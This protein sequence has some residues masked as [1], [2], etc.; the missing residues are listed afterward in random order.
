MFSYRCYHDSCSYF[1]CF[2]PRKDGPKT[3]T[4]SLPLAQLAFSSQPPRLENPVGLNNTTPP[5]CSTSEWVKITSGITIFTVRTEEGA[6][7]LPNAMG[8]NLDLL[9]P[10]SAILISRRGHTFD[11]RSHATS[12]ASQRFIVPF[13]TFLD[14]DL[15][16]A[17]WWG[18]LGYMQ[19][20]ASLLAC[21]LACLL[22]RGRSGFVSSVVVGFGMSN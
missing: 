18:L 21:L 12:Q 13:M 6:I 15:D 10:P 9:H 16:E 1:C 22:A 19:T 17:P 7:D 20:V 5:Q 14:L 11:R 3:R 2:Y 4:I 8:P